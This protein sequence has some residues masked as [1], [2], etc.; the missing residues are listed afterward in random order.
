MSERKDKKHK[1]KKHKKDKKPRLHERVGYTDDD[2]PFGDRD[3]G[4]TF[5]WKKK[6]GPEP[7]EEAAPAVARRRR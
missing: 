6:R 5:V 2:N 3:L 7:Q 4:A 1:K